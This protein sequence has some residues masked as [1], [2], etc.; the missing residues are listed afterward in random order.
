VAYP[1]KGLSQ[2]THDLRL[3]VWDVYNNSSEGYL[4]FIVASSAELALEHV[5]NYPN[6]FSTSTSFFFEHNRPCGNLSVT[7]QVFSISGKL[8]KTINEDIVCNGY[9]SDPIEWDGRDDYGQRIGR[10]V[11]MYSL[12]VRT[13]DGLTADHLDKLVI[14]N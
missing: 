10:G 6:P 3:K 4:E 1:F 7:V 9:R 14:L 5:L 13:D 12:R 8:V 2:G 11:Y